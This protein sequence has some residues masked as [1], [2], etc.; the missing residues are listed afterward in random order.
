MTPKRWRALAV[1]AI[2]AA[3]LFWGREPRPGPGT[4]ERHLSVDGVE[5]KYLVHAGGP[6]KPG[7]PLVLV[8][9]GMGGRAAEIERRTRQ[10]FDV[11]ADRYG[12]VVVYPQALGSPRRWTDGWISAAPGAPLPDD[13]R[14]ISTLV[15]ALAG[16]L[17]ID[18]RRVFAAG[19]SNGGMMV[20]RLG[21]ERPDLFAAIAPVSG[22]MAYDVARA[23]ASGPPVSV[24]AM[25]GTDDA[26]VPFDQDIRA[27]TATWTKRDGCPEAP[28]SSRLPDLDPHDGTQTRVDE[29]G[30]CAAGTDV[31]FYTIEGGGHAWPGGESI[32]GLRRRGNTPDDFDAGAVIW[33]FF[34]KHPRR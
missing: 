17:A 29:Y 13:V 30:P 14:F 6:A 11:I 2:L 10:T 26:I 34:Q 31:V 1:A 20:H 7:R 12:A 8:L 27:S 25:H 32:W 19:L 4:T 21:C 5:R 18:R 28:R 33:D 22:G 24:L 15:D 3:V 9:H 16:E 23:C